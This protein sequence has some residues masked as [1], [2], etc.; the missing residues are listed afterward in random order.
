[1]SSQ[2]SATTADH[3]NRKDGDVDD[4]DDGG[5][6]D[7]DAT[8]L[9]FNKRLSRSFIQPAIYPSVHSSISSHLFVD[10]CFKLPSTPTNCHNKLKRVHYTFFFK[11]KKISLV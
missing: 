3:N 11:E 9:R 2:C 1:M 10:Q 4:D 8:I 7:D 6:S 5:G